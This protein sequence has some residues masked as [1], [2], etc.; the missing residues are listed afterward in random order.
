MLLKLTG[1]PA[2]LDAMLTVIR[3]LE[4]RFC[5]TKAQG[6]LEGAA[7]VEDIFHTLFQMETLF[8]PMEFEVRR[9]L[10]EL[11]VDVVKKLEAVLEYHSQVLDA[12]HMVRTR[13]MKQ[14]AAG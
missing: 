4:A 14:I 8:E 9:H 7:Q 13:N 10:K 2:L 3:E 5:V 6:S 1:T 12:V 11:P